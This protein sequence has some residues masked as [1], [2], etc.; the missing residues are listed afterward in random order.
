MRLLELAPQLHQTPL[1]MRVAP[2]GRMQS[3][4]HSAADESENGGVGGANAI[5]RGGPLTVD[6]LGLSSLQEKMPIGGGILAT[7]LASMASRGLGIIGMG[8]T[9]EEEANEPA[10]NV[11]DEL[12]ILAAALVGLFKGSHYLLDDGIMEF[13]TA[14]AALAMDDLTRMS[15]SFR[16]DVKG[17]P[18]PSSA[19][20]GNGDTSGEDGIV[21]R[22]GGEEVT[23]AERASSVRTRSSSASVQ[24]PWALRKLVLTMRCV[25]SC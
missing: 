4:A 24:P 8:S 15:S 14:L 6:R 13:T 9:K 18:R 22:L 16:K 3:R 21:G 2:H 11:G 12:H 7:G 19:G 10:D 25:W 17:T 5:I 1:A 23:T 20:D